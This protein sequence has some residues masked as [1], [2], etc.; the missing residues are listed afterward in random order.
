MSIS[1]KSA[2]RVLRV[3]DHFDEIQTGSTVNEIAAALQMPASSASNLLTQMHVAGYLDHWKNGRG[4]IPSVRVSTLGIWVA[5]TLGSGGPIVNLM[6]QLSEATSELIVLAIRRG[7]TIRYIHTVPAK[8]TV[9]VH[10]SIGTVLPLTLSGI[11]RIF[12][13]SMSEKSV[14]E[15]VFRHN[16]SAGAEH[17]VFLSEI[18]KDLQEIR[19]R[20]YAKSPERLMPGA[21]GLAVAVPTGATTEPMV[22]ALS[23][24]AQTI[25]D[26]GRKWGRLMAAGAARLVVPAQQRS[27]G[28]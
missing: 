23:A 3:L 2:A 26:H 20:G 13:S 18:Q 7:D 21:S 17:H 22:L 5:P 28:Q 10:K 1:V 27:R 4:Y 6:H 15:A 25:D 11:G 19:L 14:R 12:M 24:V 8:S 16:Q 9:R